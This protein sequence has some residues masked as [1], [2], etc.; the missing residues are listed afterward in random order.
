MFSLPEKKD[1]LSQV[2]GSFSSLVLS[3][4]V[5][6]SERCT[7]FISLQD[8]HYNAI[9]ESPYMYMGKEQRRGS[10]HWGLGWQEWAAQGG[11]G[12]LFCLPSLPLLL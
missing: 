11:P 5:R 1:L 4:N 8:T 9:T 10:R 12:L 7:H 3:S 6:S 2:N